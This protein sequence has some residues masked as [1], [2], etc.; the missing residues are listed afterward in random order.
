MDADEMA[1]TDPSANSSVG[2]GVKGIAEQLFCCRRYSE[3]RTRRRYFC[4]HDRSG[5]RR[6]IGV[7]EGWFRNLTVLKSEVRYLPGVGNRFVQR[8]L[9]GSC[10]WCLSVRRGYKFLVSSAK[11][12]SYGCS[13]CWTI[14]S[15]PMYSN[16][17]IS[18]K[19]KY[20]WETDSEEV[21]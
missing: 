20:C 1:P 6:P 10:D 5:L 4:M 11:R 19:A 21:Q 14:L 7:S 16:L 18:S 2:F 3:P 17:P 9:A 12:R 15:S 13:P 8:L